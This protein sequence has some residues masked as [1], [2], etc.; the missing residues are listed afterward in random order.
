MGSTIHKYQGYWMR[1]HSE[2][3]WAGM[4]D[5]LGIQWIYEPEPVAT[6]HGWYLPDFYL[7]AAGVYLEVKGPDPT[8]VELE[9]GQDLAA[10]TGCPVMFAWG[11][12]QTDHEAVCGGMLGAFGDA[13]F[14]RVSTFELAKAIRAGLGEK[15]YWQYMRAGY[16]RP[17][18]DVVMLGD[19]MQEFLAS[20]IPRRE[21]ERA[22]AQHHR[23]LNGARLSMQTVL[24]GAEWALGHFLR[25]T[26]RKVIYG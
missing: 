16:K 26:L 18:P 25:G 2:T 7:P 19:A 15:R 24:G 12:M 8:Q 9:K 6:R 4:M 10:A 21:R 23:T 13:G 17:M 22:N 11:D 5:A 20:M 14:F 1:S 3:R